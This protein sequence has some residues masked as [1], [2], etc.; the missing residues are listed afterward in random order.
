MTHAPSL[1]Y[2]CFVSVEPASKG[3]VPLLSVRDLAVG[4]P[5]GAGFVHAIDGVS[6]DLAA[7]ESLGLVGESGSG[8]SV[9][10]LSLMRL[11]ETPPAKYVRG[12]VAF[13]GEDLLVLAE[14]DMQKRRGKDLAM[15]FQE[16]MTSLNPVYSIGTQIAEAVRLHSD[17]SRKE[18]R[19]RAVSMLAKVGVPS[20]ERN[21]D[22]YPH[23]LSGGMR[24]RAMIAMAL[25]CGP[26][27]LIA[28]EPTTALDV[29][30][31]AQILELLADLRRE[32]NMGMLL[33]THDLSVV[34]EECQRIAVMYGGRVVEEGPVATV[35]ATPK[36][37]Y[38]RGLLRSLPSAQPLVRSTDGP[39]DARGNVRR[40]RLPTIAGVVP[41]LEAM[42]SGCRFRDRC[43]QASD[44]CTEVP[45]SLP[46]KGSAGSHRVA[47][48]QAETL[49]ES[50]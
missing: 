29:T 30:I 36:H 23:Q 13:C 34:A 50:A 10:A 46:V 18:A 40:P 38:T 43:E 9:T 37:P 25:S 4:F 44:A 24:Q 3:D 11:L 7:G 41:S 5:N 12:K 39:R 16:P 14:R 20:P 1:C 15:V 31:Q 19:E 28:D 2:G 22:S 27:L 47:C 49:E 42:P 6:F 48:F 26:R 33:I 32:L 45:P 8:K 35:F 21:V 17:A